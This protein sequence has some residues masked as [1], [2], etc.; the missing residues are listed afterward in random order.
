MTKEIIKVETTFNLKQHLQKQANMSYESGRGYFLAQTRAW[1]NCIKCQQE[2]K[3]SAQEAW[4]ACFDEF[5]DGDGKLSWIQN[6]MGEKVA[7][8]VKKEATIDYRGDVK[9]RIAEGKPISV[10]VSESLQTLDTNNK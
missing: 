5:Q 8:M 2:A 3:K 7:S 9:K 1:M 6:H 10:A 4:Q